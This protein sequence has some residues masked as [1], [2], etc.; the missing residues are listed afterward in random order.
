M[1]ERGGVIGG[2]SAGASI[3][4]DFLVRGAV[5]GSQLIVAPE[6]EHHKGF[7]FLRHSAIDQHINTRNRWDDIVPLI[8]DTPRAARHRSVREHGDRRAAA[9]GSK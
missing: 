2:S 7:A 5:Q 4:G 3:Q 8:K 1:L 6:P 9:I